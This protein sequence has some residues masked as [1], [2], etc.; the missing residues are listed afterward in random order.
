MSDDHGLTRVPDRARA[1]VELDRLSQQSFPIYPYDVRL[2]IRLVLT[3]A[4]QSERA[5]AEAERPLSPAGRKL[6]AHAIQIIR[7][8]ANM[9]LQV[10][11]EES[12]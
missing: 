6:L 2:A 4:A 12:D 5:V 1:A 7:E 11:E 10:C 8:N 3:A 9:E